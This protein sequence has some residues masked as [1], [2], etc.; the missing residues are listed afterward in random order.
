M[1]DEEEEEKKEDD[2]DGEEEEEE[3]EQTPTH[4]TI[5]VT[6]KQIRRNKRTFQ[7]FNQ[8]ISKRYRVVLDKSRIQKDFSSVPFGMRQES[9]LQ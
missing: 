6:R 9:C 4:E 2:D 5:S 3:E 1:Q 7:L 8:D